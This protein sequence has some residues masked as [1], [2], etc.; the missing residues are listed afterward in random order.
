MQERGAAEL[1]RGEYK[2]D[3]Y[4]RLPTIAAVGRGDLGEKNQKQGDQIGSGYL[5]D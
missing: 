4:G 2:E 1:L 3:A 5:Q